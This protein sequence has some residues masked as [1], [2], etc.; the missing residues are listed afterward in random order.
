MVVIMFIFM[1]YLVIST[2]AALPLSCLVPEN[3]LTGTSEGCMCQQSYSSVLQ[4]PPSLNY[5]FISVALCLLLRLCDLFVQIGK[6][7]LDELLCS[8]N[9]SQQQTRI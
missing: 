5:F 3:L 6:S 2:T 8:V 9:S 7:L 1:Q 4:P